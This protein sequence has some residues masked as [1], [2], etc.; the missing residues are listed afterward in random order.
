MSSCLLTR[1]DTFQSLSYMVYMAVHTTNYFIFFQKLYLSTIPMVLHSLIFLLPP[2][3]LLLRCSCVLFF[4]S[5]SSDVHI[6]RALSSSISSSHSAVSFDDSSHSHGFSY[7]SATLIQI[8]LLCL[9]VMYQTY[10]KICI[11]K[12]IKI[13]T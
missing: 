5:L 13:Y 7:T 10:I 12:Y 4:L 6:L 2:F 11:Y 9:R 1:M 3:L 8:F